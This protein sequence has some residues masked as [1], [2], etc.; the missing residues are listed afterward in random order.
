MDKLG[1]LGME[2]GRVKKRVNRAKR[3]RVTRRKEMRRGPNRRPRIV[4]R[5]AMLNKKLWIEN[6]IVY[7]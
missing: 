3:P 7:D 4:K 6:G 2:L 5:F 1:P